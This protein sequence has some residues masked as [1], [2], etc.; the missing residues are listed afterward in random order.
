MALDAYTAALG[1]EVGLT[2][3]V[4]LDD[5]FTTV[6]AWPGPAHQ[7]TVMSRASCC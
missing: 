2:G 6:L 3:T 7:G 4:D 5:E 1:L